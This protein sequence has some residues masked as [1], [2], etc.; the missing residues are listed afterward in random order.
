M[1]ENSNPRCFFDVSI[2]GEKGM[3]TN[4]SVLESEN[5]HD[6]SCMHAH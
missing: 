4:F 5:G 6:A 1:S 2:G 3:L